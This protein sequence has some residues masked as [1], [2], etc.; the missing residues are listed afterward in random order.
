MQKRRQTTYRLVGWRLLRVY[1]AAREAAIAGARRVRK[2][3]KGG[4][5]GRDGEVSIPLIRRDAATVTDLQA[6]KIAD[7]TRR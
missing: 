3:R 2:G 6:L 4:D 1:A 7:E 5:R